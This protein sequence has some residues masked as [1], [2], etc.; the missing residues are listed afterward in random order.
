MSDADQSIPKTCSSC[1]WWG[2]GP[3]P[4]YFGQNRRCV[5]VTR[6]GEVPYAA[7]VSP[8]HDNNYMSDLFTGPEFGC[9]HHQPNP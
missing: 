5:Q 2:R 8:L 3:N 7:S 6:D 1:R 9:I 4:T